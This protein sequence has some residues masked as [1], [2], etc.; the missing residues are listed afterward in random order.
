[1][2][3]LRANFP[4]SRTALSHRTC[5]NRRPRNGQHVKY[6]KIL[7][8]LCRSCQP[9]L[10]AWKC[11]WKPGKQVNSHCMLLCLGYFHGA[12][13]ALGAKLGRGRLDDARL[14]V[15]HQSAVGHRNGAVSIC[16]SHEAVLALD[17]SFGHLKKRAIYNAYR[18]RYSRVLAVFVVYLFEG[19]VT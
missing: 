19:L 5:E 8:A 3:N 15:G 14:I 1:M 17:L 2:E 4:H 16:S 7:C 10:I 11:Q 12:H 9:L 13:P 6:C 18:V